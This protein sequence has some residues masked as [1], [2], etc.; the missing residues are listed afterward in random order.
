MKDASSDAKNRQGIVMLEVNLQN[1][2]NEDLSDSALSQLDTIL[3]AWQRH[4]S[5]VILRFLYDWDGK[6]METEP[7][8]LE[9]ILRHMDQTA[10]VVNRYTD[11]DAGHFCRKLRG[12]EQFSL[13]VR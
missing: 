6:A 11:C 13:H 7:Q 4:G 12:N 2:S 10:E 9:Q 3:S 1:F 5:Q 8:S